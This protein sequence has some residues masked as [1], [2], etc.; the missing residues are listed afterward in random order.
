MFPL[1]IAGGFRLGKGPYGAGGTFCHVIISVL[2][3]FAYFYIQGCY[4]AAD[5][6][7]IG[8]LDA[9]PYVGD[10]LS[11]IL[12][13][14]FIKASALEII[15]FVVGIIVAVVSNPT[16]KKNGRKTIQQNDV[17]I[18]P[19]STVDTGFTG[20]DAY[21]PYANTDTQ[22]FSNAYDAYN[23]QSTAENQDHNAQNVNNDWR[24]VYGQNSDNNNNNTFGN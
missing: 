9:A 18:T 11:I 23:T 17:F 22:N 15:L 4:Y 21:N 20:Y 7:K 12:D 24:D 8:M 14:E 3:M 2:A 5:W 19:L 1:F 10:I 16:S 6:Y 13:P